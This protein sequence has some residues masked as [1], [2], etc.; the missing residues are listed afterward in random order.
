MDFLK[1]LTTQIC[2][3][4]NIPCPKISYVTSDFPSK[5]MLAK[6]VPE[7]NTIYVKDKKISVD[8][9]FALAH[10]LRHVW[11]MTTDKNLYFG[12][13]KQAHECSNKVEYNLQLAELDAN[14]FAGIITSD[15]FHLK[16]TFEGLPEM[17]K[18]KIYERMEEILT[19]IGI[20]K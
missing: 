14:A 13:Y 19:E 6:Y 8:V 3:I 16:P 12:S 15:L 18:D 2:E 17:V 1:E 10:E 11:Q 5:T 7:E 20:K 4:L 9:C